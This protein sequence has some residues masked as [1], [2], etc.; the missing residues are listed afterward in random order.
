MDKDNKTDLNDKFLEKYI[1]HKPKEKEMP[2]ITIM[3]H[4]DKEKSTQH[5]LTSSALLN[6]KTRLGHK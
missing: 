5:I 1:P 2:S 4:K 3:K 6:N